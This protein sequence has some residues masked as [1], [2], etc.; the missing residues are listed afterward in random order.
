MGLPLDIPFRPKRVISP[1]GWPAG[2]EESPPLAPRRR[3]SGPLGAPVLEDPS[4]SRGPSPAWPGRDPSPEERAGVPSRGIVIHA[5]ARG[6]VWRLASKPSRG[7]IRRR[8]VHRDRGAPRGRRQ[9]WVLG[10]TF[11]EEWGEGSRPGS[12]QLRPPLGSQRDALLLELGGRPITRADPGRGPGQSSPSLPSSFGAGKFPR[13]PRQLLRA[14]NHPRHAVRPFGNP[15]RAHG[16]APPF[17]AAPPP[18]AGRG[19][20]RTPS[21][22]PRGP[23]GLPPPG[24]PRARRDSGTSRRTR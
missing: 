5:R 19:R 22:R 20:P 4:R 6:A 1:G 12:R 13:A 3:R 17:T 14:D 18:A 8:A 16:D 7:G 24:A 21:G 23:R 15:G 10:R 9:V 11:D 2:R